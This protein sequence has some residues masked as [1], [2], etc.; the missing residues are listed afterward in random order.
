MYFPDR[1]FDRDGQHLDLRPINS[2]ALKLDA[3]STPELLEVK[4][5]NALA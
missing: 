3:I 5:I 2:W 4:L 1:M